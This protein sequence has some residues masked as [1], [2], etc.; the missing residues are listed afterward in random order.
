M[1]RALPTVEQRRRERARKL[2]HGKAKGF[3]EHAEQGA[4]FWRDAAPEVKFQAIIELVQAAWVL[5]GNDEPAPRLDR[6]AHGVRKL[7]G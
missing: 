1:K 2:V 6:S 4:A 7:R 3:E 5:G